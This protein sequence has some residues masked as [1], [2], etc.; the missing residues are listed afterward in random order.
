MKLARRSEDV[1]RTRRPPHQGQV[2]N[3]VDHVI[4]MTI[5]N[6]CGARLDIFILLN[7]APPVQ[8]GF[9]ATAQQ[10]IDFARIRTNSFFCSDWRHISIIKSQPA[11]VSKDYNNDWTG[12]A[13]AS[14]HLARVA[15]DIEAEVSDFQPGAILAANGRN[16]CEIATEMHADGT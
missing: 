5:C 11:K 7:E 8:N 3:V 15:A 10:A 9:F 4:T 13:V 16:I 12:C 6:I 14:V 1:V 2:W